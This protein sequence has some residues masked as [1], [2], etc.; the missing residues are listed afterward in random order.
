MRVQLSALS[1]STCPLPDPGIPFRNYAGIQA[2]WR[3]ASRGA[4]TGTY[5]RNIIS[6][7]SPSNGGNAWH[8][9]PEHITPP[10]VDP[11]VALMEFEEE[12][13]TSICPAHHS[14]LLVA[15]LNSG[16]FALS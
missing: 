2:P 13:F 5:N 10:L 11:N 3:S 9:P 8:T 7:L 1:T 6:S 15:S 12:S 14:V 4:L 16:S